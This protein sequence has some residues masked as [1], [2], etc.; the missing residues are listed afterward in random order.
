METLILTKG[1]INAE[2]IKE[3]IIKRKN[4]EARIV[5][6]TKWG[7]RFIKSIVIYKNMICD[8]HDFFHPVIFEWARS[9]EFLS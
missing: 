5:I 4:Q 6:I 1:D 8:V 3:E 9:V 2:R 7:C